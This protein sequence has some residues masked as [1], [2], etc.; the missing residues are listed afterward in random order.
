MTN[1]TAVIASLNDAF[2]KTLNSPVTHANRIMFTSG[3]ND[4]GFEFVQQA[5]TAVMTFDGF[6]E[7]NDPDGERDF[8]NFEL[9]DQKL[10]WK[11]DYYATPDMEHGSDDPSDPTKTVRILTVL[12]AS[13]Y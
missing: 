9:Q 6:S 5:L 2:R 13:E 7:D 4:Q 3:V 10:F 11:I 8:G 12:L 1:N